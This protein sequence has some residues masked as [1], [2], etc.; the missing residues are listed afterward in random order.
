MAQY[1]EYLK[2]RNTLLQDQRNRKLEKE[3]QIS[4]DFDLTAEEL[5]NRFETREKQGSFADRTRYYFEDAVAME[6]KALRYHNLADNGADMDAY[7][8]RYSY[9][10]AG[11]RKKSAK[12]AADAFQRAADLER[13]YANE[14]VDALTKFRH[15]EEIMKARLEGMKAAAEV[16]S[17]SKE[18]EAYRVLKAKISCLTLLKE[19][20][21][22][23]RA[24]TND[25]R[26]SAT[27]KKEWERI[28][29]E[30]GEA[31]TEMK[32]MVPS[33]TKQ[34]EEAIGIPGS[35]KERLKAF[36][37]VDPEYT[38]EEAANLIR[39]KELG[40][41]YRRPDLQDA[42]TELQRN[43]LYGDQK[44]E[45]GDKTRFMAFP[46][47]TVLRDK[48][49]LPINQEELK[50]AEHNKRWIEA[51]KE[52]NAEKKNAVLLE[53]LQYYEKLE[54]PS[55]RDI[56]ERGIL[57]YLK[58]KPAEY[59]EITRMS[60]TLSNI[61]KKDPF[62]REYLEQHP[63][64]SKK[65]D[66]G[67]AF[68][69]FCT[70]ALQKWYSIKESN[71]DGDNT[72]YSVDRAQREEKKQTMPDALL[73]GLLS[74]YEE[75]YE[76]A[77]GAGPVRYEIMEQLDEKEKKAMDIFHESY[78]DEYDKAK[79][80][81]LKDAADTQLAQDLLKKRT[82][83]EL[84]E[85][86]G[87]AYEK[88][89]SGRTLSRSEKVRNAERTVEKKQLQT[90]LR[91]HMNVFLGRRKM[92]QAG[93]LKRDCY[94]TV[95]RGSTQLVEKTK[96]IEHIRNKE[97]DEQYLAFALDW[98]RLSE[99]DTPSVLSRAFQEEKKEAL[100][101]QVK[102]AGAYLL[103]VPI[104]EFDYQSDTEFVTKLHEKYAWIERA[105]S[106]KEV[107]EKAKADGYIYT[108]KNLAISALEARLKVF[109]EIKKDYDARIAML[110]SPYYALLTDTD[111]KTLTDEELREK[112]EA[113]GGTDA[114][115]SAFLKNYRFLKDRKGAFG[116][117]AS[118]AEREKALGE[119]PKQQ[120][121]HRQQQLLGEIRNMGLLPEESEGRDAYRKRLVR[122]LVQKAEENAP[123]VN[124]QFLQ[125]KLPH[126]DNGVGNLNDAQIVEMEKWLA[127]TFADEG[128]LR[129]K[130]L[131]GEEIERLKDLRK[132][133]L[134]ARQLLENR[135]YVQLQL[136]KGWNSTY[137]E[138]PKQ[139][140]LVDQK[141]YETLVY[142]FE[143]YEDNMNSLGLS[144]RNVTVEEHY[145][146]ALSNLTSVLSA[147]GIY[148]TKDAPKLIKDGE[149][150]AKTEAEEEIGKGWKT[151]FTIGGEE[152]RMI[153]DM[154][155]FLELD[156]K[157]VEERDRAVLSEKLKEA[158]SRY[159][160]MRALAKIVDKRK[161]GVYITEF[162]NQF[163]KM[164]KEMET[165][166]TEI[167]ALLKTEESQTAQKISVKYTQ[168][169]QEPV[170]M[171]PRAKEAP[172]TAL[173]DL[174]TEYRTFL[175]ELRSSKK[176]GLFGGFQANS[177]EFDRVIRT[178]MK[179]T[180]LLEGDA[181][182]SVEK[183]RTEGEWLREALQESID[184]ANKYLAKS[185][186][187][188]TDGGNRK[189]LVGKVRQKL[190]ADLASLK[191]ALSTFSQENAE[192]PAGFS[193]STLLRSREI[194]IDV[195]LDDL[196]H[197]GGAMSDLAELTKNE[198]PYGGG[199]FKK[200]ESRKIMTDAELMAD[201]K[202]KALSEFAQDGYQL[203]EEERQE[204]N[205]I[206][207]INAREVTEWT[208]MLYI[209]K[210][211][212]MRHYKPRHNEI[213]H[214][215]KMGLK[216]KR[217]PDG[218][219]GI[220]PGDRDVA[221]FQMA[222]LFGQAHLVAKCEKVV[223]K[224]KGQNIRGHLMNKAVGVVAGEVQSDL[225]A[226][227]LEAIEQNQEASEGKEI[228]TGAFIKQLMNLQVLDYLCGQKDRHTGNYLVKKDENGKLIAL[229][230]IDNNLA[231]PGDPA[232]N[233]IGSNLPPL[234]QGNG[235]LNIKY[236]DAEFAGTI[237]A[238]RP[239]FLRNALSG[240]LATEEIDLTV[241][242]L[243]RLQ[244]AIR[245]ELDQG[246]DSMFLSSD[247]QWMEHA[248]DLMDMKDQYDP[249][250]LGAL[251]NDTKGHG[252]E[253]FV[254]KKDLDKAEKWIRDRKTMDHTV[255]MQD[256]DRILAAK[257]APERAY[258]SKLRFL[259]KKEGQVFDP[260]KILIDRKGL[261]GADRDLARIVVNQIAYCL[262]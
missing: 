181:P 210:E 190:Q 62:V 103:T 70:N 172:S 96:E 223:V 159:L 260:E 41:E 229:T 54:L 59:M 220:N 230:G 31:E 91:Q 165:L 152:I 45:D 134:A 63:H 35:L 112:A 182:S 175:T 66:A 244:A 170:R 237:L 110:N 144:K 109:E 199:L 118:A 131:S 80:K 196:K 227:R 180:G 249:S 78:P 37:Q 32:K 21:K 212:L 26:M 166:K 178:M 195:S 64:L 89:F 90:A 83:E 254:M 27:L 262:K 168:P 61:Q 185:G 239:E 74:L 88:V 72:G 193:F 163:L 231:F 13:T 127:G 211:Y 7:A 105:A 209:A 5:K 115:L 213:S 154:S 217:Q 215:R 67:V 12:K 197:Y 56:R 124:E 108:S 38:E 101:S 111:L 42:V 147:H 85:L 228:L 79:R 253:R 140:D 238:M 71:L 174:K 205:K 40:K 148:F 252:M 214:L 18:N 114:E 4:S 9:H 84:S 17:R 258:F 232:Y 259:V 130:G 99:N 167:Q 107:Y 19:Q 82:P 98:T 65:G 100:V 240:L 156:G 145:G 138:N 192:I 224:S 8:S 233:F 133:Q 255:F 162:R 261:T 39:L 20:A 160:T 203:T 235:E 52:G 76:L 183:L 46:L 128:K 250:Y 47:R 16:K 141:D 149:E 207:S 204:F 247:Q 81:E 23:L 225:Y 24:S 191:T 15:R 194:R 57:W 129:E 119:E 155:F 146:D 219:N 69:T 150:A 121:A 246:H 198:D 236:M 123:K 48:N 137:L 106:L 188:T 14:N 93:A 234:V 202:E 36:R 222:A 1:E 92:R 97:L 25:E 153:R 161:N 50:K 257:N 30:L 73:E 245:Q 143:V 3:G 75:S 22:E 176:G 132:K 11:K 60:T 201:S 243:E 256:L 189:T 116:K 208:P 206:R 186:G 120:E 34:W 58:N 44:I 122:A 171:R 242:R 68:N 139:N 135:E 102:S 113:I 216:E 251:I 53:T 104:S 87:E 117:K 29:E 55:P 241:Q 177:P 173:E 169:K 221:T 51:L 218:T 94:G 158:E 200:D 126:L 136:C 151:T 86:T 184:A 77:Y 43:R 2:E 164:E 179:T 125:E 33:K 95:G 157:F 187:S 142:V 49:G 226:R 10:S 6:A 248:D 28:S